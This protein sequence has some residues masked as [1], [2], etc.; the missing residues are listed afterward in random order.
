MLSPGMHIPTFPWRKAFRGQQHEA[1]QIH[2]AAP[3]AGK[4]GMKIWEELQ[5]FQLFHQI[6]KIKG[7]EN[8]GIL[9]DGNPAWKICRISS[10]FILFSYF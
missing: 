3:T 10:E 7:D 6:S 2:G 9:Q 8:V 1:V 4:L 5:I